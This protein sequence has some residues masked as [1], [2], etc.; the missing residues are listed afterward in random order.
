MTGLQ[1]IAVIVLAVQG[2]KATS[3]VYHHPISGKRSVWL[4]IV[5]F[6]AWSLETSTVNPPIGF[7]WFQAAL[8]GLSGF[9]MYDFIVRFYNAIKGTK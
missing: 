4:Y 3:A 2:I 6:L 1:H 7:L 5:V 8:Y 9:G